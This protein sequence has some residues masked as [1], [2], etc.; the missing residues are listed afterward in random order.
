MLRLMEPT[1]PTLVDRFFVLALIVKGFDGVL[2]IIGGTLLIVVPLDS[3][4]GLATSVI[5]E[6][7][8]SNH[9]FIADSIIKLNH[10]L[11]P[12]LALFGAL[13]LL[14]HGIVKVGL[15]IALLSRRYVLYPYAIGVL[16]LFTLYQAYEFIY[17]PSLGLAT[18]TIFDIVIV[19]LTYVEWRRHTRPASQLPG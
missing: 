6:L 1:K 15:V 2:E 13:Y 19:V 12:G 7:Q 16:I 9:T 3:L 17:N 11:T 10:D 8:D 14:I 4:H 18:L 5:Y